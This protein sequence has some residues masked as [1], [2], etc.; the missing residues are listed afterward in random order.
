MKSISDLNWD[1]LKTLFFVFKK[2]NTQSGDSNWSFTVCRHY[3][4]QIGFHVMPSHY[5][6]RS[7]KEGFTERFVTQTMSYQTTLKTSKSLKFK[8]ERTSES[9]GM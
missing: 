6:N 2:Q 5:P 4:N 7:R 8:F 9:L 1:S 3:K